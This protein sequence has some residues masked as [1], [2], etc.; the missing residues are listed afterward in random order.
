MSNRKIN[1]EIVPHCGVYVT[2][3]MRAKDC[4][5]TE[6]SLILEKAKEFLEKAK[7]FKGEQY[8]LPY[9]TPIDLGEVVL[10]NT[11][12]FPNVILA[13]QYAESI[14]PIA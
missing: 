6:K 7:E 11:F 10:N 4:T 3:I 5:E 13:E 8:D 2:I 1:V 9:H 14:S 12:V